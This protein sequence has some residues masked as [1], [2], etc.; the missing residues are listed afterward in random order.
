MSDA[1]KKYRHEVRQILEEAQ[2]VYIRL[3]VLKEGITVDATEALL[4]ERDM[5]LVGAAGSGKTTVLR[6]PAPDEP[7]EPPE[8][9]EVS[10]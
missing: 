10:F 5:F 1:L 6:H 2:S 9:D 8:D 7:S 3:Q 4:R